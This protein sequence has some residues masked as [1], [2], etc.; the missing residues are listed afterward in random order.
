MAY[1]R[2]ETSVPRHWKFLQAGPAA[3]WL[4]T[5]GL[6]Y[7]QDGLTDGFIPDEAV[8]HLG[9]NGA[10]VLSMRLV[11]ARLW[12]TRPNGFQVHDYLD[13][14]RAAEDIRAIKDERRR[15]G[16]HGGKASALNRKAESGTQ[17]RQPNSQHDAEANVKQSA[18]ANAQ[19]PLNPS[20]SVAVA[21][22]EAVSRD[23]T[24]PPTASLALPV[25]NSKPPRG[26]DGRAEGSPQQH[27][28]SLEPSAKGSFGVVRNLAIQSIADAPK[29]DDV[30][31]I[32]RVKHDCA[33]LGIDYQGD[34]VHRAVA[35]ARSY[36][37]IHGVPAAS[38]VAAS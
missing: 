10:R 6:A 4:W 25:E 32:E 8:A 14:N 12:E 7:C 30:E 18:E 35:S 2:I 16:A 19:H 34:V 13:W 20:V 22:A 1:M 3:C 28:K 15:A 9:V 29:V 31:L 21:V 33:R 17:E 38:T 26:G 37:L 36:V 5:C 11:A 27:P 24:S 23:S